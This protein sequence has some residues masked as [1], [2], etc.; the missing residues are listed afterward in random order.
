MHRT[1]NVCFLSAPTLSGCRNSLSPSITCFTAFAP[2]TTSPSTAV[3]RNTRLP[4][5]IGDECERPSI[6]TFHLMFFVGL[7]SAGRFFSV[8]T[9]EPSGPRHPGQFPAAALLANDPTP[10][11]TK[12]TII[13]SAIR[14]VCLTASILFLKIHLIRGLLLSERVQI[15]DRTHDQQSIR[16]R[17]RGHH[18]F[19]YRV[20]R[21]Q[22]IFRSGLD[23]EHVAIFARKINLPVRCNG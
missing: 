9:P 1:L 2:G 19:S 5:T 13:V 21:E 18:H 20:L 17:R 14:Y 12:A 7:H 23:D 11:T 3:V 16:D 8:E 15:R 10:T 6:A 4:H 22:L